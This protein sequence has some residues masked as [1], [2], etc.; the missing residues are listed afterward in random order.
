MEQD[1]SS[2]SAGLAELVER[3]GKSAVAVEARHRI[4]SSGFLWKPGLIVTAEHAIRR[5]DDIPVILPSGDRSM[6]ELAG[7]DPGTDVA[8]LRVKGA[9]GA[10]DP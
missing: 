9:G 2:F 7:R 5:D 10:D 1:L 8:V 3:A 6:A 4:G